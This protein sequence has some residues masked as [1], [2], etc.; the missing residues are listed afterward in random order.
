MSAP[1]TISSGDVC[2][3]DDLL[4]RRLL[5]RRSPSSDV[6]SSDDLP[7]PTSPLA[8]I[9]SGFLLVVLYVLPAKSSVS[10][11]CSGSAVQLAISSHS[12]VQS[13]FSGYISLV[14]GR[15]LGLGARFRVYE[16]I[17][18]FYKG[19]MKKLVPCLLYLLVLLLDCQ[20]QLLL[21]LLMPL[22]LQELDHSALCYQRDILQLQ[23]S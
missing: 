5:Q 23:G 18:A 21:Q 17:T 14:L 4:L 7:P 9:S 10:P 8:T 13:Q 11:F 20:L 19:Q 16:I 1:A 15:I 2:S 3:S 6:S 12:R 22:I